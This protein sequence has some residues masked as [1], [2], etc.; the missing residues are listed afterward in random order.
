MYYV[1]CRSEILSVKQGVMPFLSGG[2]GFQWVGFNA[3]LLAVLNG[4]SLIHYSTHFRGFDRSLP[5]ASSDIDV[6]VM[7]RKQRYMH[8]TQVHIR[9]YILHVHMYT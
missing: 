9:M 8:T 1:R 5:H 6:Y 3:V 4:T 7:I 2:A